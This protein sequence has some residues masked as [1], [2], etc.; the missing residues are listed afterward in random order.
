MTMPGFTG[1]VLAAQVR[2]LRPEIPV[3]LVSGFSDRLTA[4]EVHAAGFDG[5]VDTPL[6]PT[7]LAQLISKLC[8]RC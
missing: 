2:R 6:R 5:F 3:G 1:E 7:T 8:D 4:E